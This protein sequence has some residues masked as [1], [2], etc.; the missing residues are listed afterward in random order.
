MLDSLFSIR[1]GQYFMIL[2]NVWDML[3]GISGD[4]SYMEDKG[5]I[6]VKSGI[7]LLSGEAITVWREAP[8][9][10][11]PQLCLPGELGC[12]ATCSASAP[13]YFYYHSAV[14]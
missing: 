4:G 9:V 5:W 3:K 2:C 14:F 8:I 10:V 6:L 11:N 1:L 7:E 12:S 13:C